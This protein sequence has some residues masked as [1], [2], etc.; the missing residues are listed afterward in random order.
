MRTPR[1]EPDLF[2]PWRS[3]VPFHEHAPS[4]GEAP[5][6]STSLA[7]LTYQ[8]GRLGAHVVFDTGPPSSPPVS[9]SRPMATISSH[10]FTDPH[11]ATDPLMRF[12]QIGC[13]ELH[14]APRRT[15]APFFEMS[16]GLHL[17]LGGSQ[18]YNNLLASVEPRTFVSRASKQWY[19]SSSD[20]S[21]R[22][23]LSTTGSWIEPTIDLAINI[24]R[25]LPPLYFWT[26][27][28]EKCCPNSLKYLFQY[29]SEGPLFLSSSLRE[30]GRAHV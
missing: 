19:T 13:S 17:G 29:S 11:P 22:M 20:K 25:L 9:R 26:T 16:V 3:I 21:Q 8:T 12:T 27:M 1:P 4:H 2:N 7:H 6:A 5:K 28:S 18:L 23:P 14:T 30:I 15:E 24:V 10:H